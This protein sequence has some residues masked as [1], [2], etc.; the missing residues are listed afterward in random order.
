MNDETTPRLNPRRLMLA[1]KRRGFTKERLAAESG[2]STRSLSS[3]EKGTQEPSELT[4]HSLASQLRF[5]VAFF[6]NPTDIDELPT[7][8]PSFRALSKLTARERDKAFAAA[9]LTITLDNWIQDKFTLPEVAVPQFRGIDPETAAEAVR[10]KWRLGTKPIKSMI[11]LLEQHGVRVFS[12]AEEYAS[13]DAFSLWKSETP[14]VFISTVKSAER[15]RMDAA[16]ELGHLVL[17]WGHGAPRGRDY[18]REAEIFASALLMPRASVI[19]EV[20]RNATLDQIIQLKHR[21]KV[22][23]KALAYRMHTLK[24]LSEWHYRSIFVQLSKRGYSRSEPEGAAPETSRVLNMVF[25]DLHREG[26]TRANVADA[27]AV[28][29][30]D[31]DEALFGLALV[32]ISGEG[33]ASPIRTRPALRLVHPT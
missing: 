18:E 17:H 5:P 28:Q 24:M 3:Y 13:V 31:I 6:T 15:Q 26:I 4:L 19:A 12:L 33:E 1:R 21:W 16:H 11:Y 9:A 25:S 7:D 14:Y 23:A 30:S 20:P 29:P 27:L 10:A 22:S 2:L 32:G 8:G